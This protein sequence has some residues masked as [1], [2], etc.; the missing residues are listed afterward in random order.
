MIRSYEFNM[1]LEIKIT[2]DC[3]FLLKSNF[4]GDPGNDPEFMILKFM[5][6]IEMKFFRMDHFCLK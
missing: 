5:N 4:R 2:A 6:G 1:S 3:Q